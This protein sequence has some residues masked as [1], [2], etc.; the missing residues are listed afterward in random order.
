MSQ[1]PAQKLRRNSTPHEPSEDKAWLD[2]VPVGREIGSPDYERL[3]A[4]DHAAFAAFQSWERGRVWLVEPNSQLDGAC[5][6]DAARSPAGFSK[7]MSILMS[8]GCRADEGFMREIEAF[9]VQDRDSFKS[10]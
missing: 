7:V 9:Q 4:L 2:A 5:P 8:S 3:M 10:S 1:T 6:Q